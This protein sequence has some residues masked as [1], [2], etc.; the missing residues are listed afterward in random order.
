M[1]SSTGTSN[2]LPS[3]ADVTEQAAPPVCANFDDRVKHGVARPFLLSVEV[4]VRDE[5]AREIG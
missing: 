1:R 3:T 2:G 5:E 4:T